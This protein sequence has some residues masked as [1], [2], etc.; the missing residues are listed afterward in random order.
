MIETVAY[1]LSPNIIVS[2]R[3]L[4]VMFLSAAI[5]IVLLPL[6]ALE[7]DMLIHE[8]TEIVSQAK[9]ALT[10]IYIVSPLALKLR[11]VSLEVISGVTAGEGVFD[12][13]VPNAILPGRLSS[14]HD[15]NK[16][17]TANK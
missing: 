16:M 17:Q 11:V 7:G 2:V 4:G 6:A 12:G 13:G 3:V 8:G 14:V 1:F 9:L 15:I 5:A 10:L